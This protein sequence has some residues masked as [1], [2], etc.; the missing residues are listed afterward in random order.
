MDWCKPH[1]GEKN[2]QFSQDEVK[3]HLVKY[4]SPPLGGGAGSMESYMSTVFTGQKCL[5]QEEGFWSGEFCDTGGSSVNSMF[6]SP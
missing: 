5:T 4:A 2:V 3:E 6:L 1:T